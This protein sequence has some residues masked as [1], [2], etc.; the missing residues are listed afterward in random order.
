MKNGT[1]TAI[2][3][4]AMDPG[5]RR[6]LATRD[7]VGELLDALEEAKVL[8]EA[9]RMTYNRIR[10]HSGRCGSDVERGVHG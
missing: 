10:P 1:Q 9:R 7:S 8:V 3:M 4:M 6:C 5:S 2:Q